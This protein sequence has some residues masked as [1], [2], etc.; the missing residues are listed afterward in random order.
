[1]RPKHAINFK[2]R[3]EIQTELIGLQNKVQGGERIF[4]KFYF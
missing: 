2:N 4:V 3:E 1:M